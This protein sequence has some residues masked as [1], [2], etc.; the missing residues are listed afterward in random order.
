MPISAARMLKHMCSVGPS[1]GNDLS[2][3]LA[4]RNPLWSVVRTLHESQSSARVCIL[5]VSSHAVLAVQLAASVVSLPLLLVVGTPLAGF[6]EGCSLLQGSYPR[7]GGQRGG[8]ERRDQRQRSPS[9][10]GLDD[11]AADPSI[12]AAGDRGGRSDRAQARAA[13]CECW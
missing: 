9:G 7:G 13:H 12:A 4:C 3:R 11:G 8:H 10:G 6:S 2:G 5:F 1:G